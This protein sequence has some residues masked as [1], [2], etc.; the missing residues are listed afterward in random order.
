LAELLL[1]RFRRGHARI[2]GRR[3]CIGFRAAPGVYRRRTRLIARF[4]VR[5]R[6]LS[7]RLVAL[8]R[9]VEN[10]GSSDGNHRDQNQDR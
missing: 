8:P 1:G 2:D 4:G 10:S 9:Q 5:D 7:G 6:G 3:R